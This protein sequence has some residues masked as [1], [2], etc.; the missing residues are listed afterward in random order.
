MLKESVAMNLSE[1][2]KTYEV[3]C[4]AHLHANP[5][6][7]IGHVKHKE[8]TQC[9]YLS[10]FEQ[11]G[12]FFAKYEVGCEEAVL[13]LLLKFCAI[14]NDERLEN[15]LNE[16]DIG[17][18]SAESNFAEEEAEQI[19]Q[20]L[21]N[22]NANLIISE[23]LEFHKNADNIA[24]LLS[25]VAYYCEFNII[26]E[27]LNENIISSKLQIAHVIDELDSYDGAIVYKY[28]SDVSEFIYSSQQFAIANKVKNNDE[29]LIKTKTEEFKRKLKIKQS[30]KG[31]IGLLP[32]SQVLS[33]PYEI[34]KIT[35]VG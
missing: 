34:S 24:K 20:K 16:L 2:L 12:D 30:L 18:L 28:V 8:Q 1:A 29:I 10:P 13:A 26:Y 23:D 17:Y 7:M 19:A 3:P 9:M 11:E 14:K 27:K 32:V 33:Y 22:K 21:K 15:F 6:L 31:T 25:M 35:Q 5:C 4:L